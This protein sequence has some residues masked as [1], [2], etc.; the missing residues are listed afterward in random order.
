MFGHFGTY[1]YVNRHY[2]VLVLINDSKQNKHN[3]KQKGGRYQ[4]T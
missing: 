3:D 4:D 1:Y 2:L